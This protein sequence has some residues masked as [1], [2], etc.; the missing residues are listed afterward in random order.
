MRSRVEEAAAD[1]ERLTAELDERTRGLDELEAMTEAVLGVTDTPLV[2]VG[3]DRRVRA[4]SRG[5]AEALGLSEPHLGRALSTVLPD[6]ILEAVTDHL[7]RVWSATRD[8]DG[9]PASSIRAGRWAISVEPL[10][11][12]GAV[13]V[14]REA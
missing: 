7:E 6:D 11:N 12:D 14:L 13:V 1:I 10:E 2:V 8:G 3:E 9:E 5:A 4:V